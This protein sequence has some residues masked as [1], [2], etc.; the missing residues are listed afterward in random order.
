MTSYRERLS[1]S[2]WMILAVGLVVPATLLIFLPL[3]PL[4]GAVVGVV[5]WG[6][7]IGILWFFSPVITV[8]DGV[9]R[10]G[11]ATLEPQYR[12]EIGA[13]LGDDARR[14]RG[15]GAD[16]RAWLSLRPWVDPVLKIHL[17]DPDDPTPYWLISTRRPDELKTALQ[18]T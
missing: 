17:T 6:G 2:W 9:L 12:G 3:S 8:V 1:P 11:G 4:T 13:Y 7:S 16:G 14:E 5:L 10:V 18:T 15:P